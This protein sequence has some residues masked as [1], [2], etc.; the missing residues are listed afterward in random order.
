MKKSLKKVISLIL[1]AVMTFGVCAVSASAYNYPESSKTATVPTVYVQGYGTAIYADKNDPNSGIIIGGGQDFI[2]DGVLGQLISDIMEP[3]FKGIATGDY[4]E[5][6]DTIVNALVADLGRFALDENGEASD[7][8]GN[9]CNWDKATNNRNWYGGK[10]HIQEYL[11]GYDWRVDIFES[12]GNLNGYI[13]QVKKVT[14][15]DKVNLVGRCMGANIVLAYLSEYGYDSINSLSL[16]IAGLDGFETVTSFF[17][18]EIDVDTDALI[19]WLYQQEVSEDYD[20]LV[21]FLKAFAT[22]I[23]AIDGLNLPLELVYKIYDQVYTDIIPRVLRE[24]F[25]SMPA[26][27]SCVAPGSYETA[28]AL[29]FPTEVE[30]TKY[31][32]LIEK[33]DRYY[34]QV[35][36]HVEDIINTA[37]DKGIPVYMFAKYGLASAPINDNAKY[38]SDGTVSVYTQALGATSTEM[39][40]TF[41]KTYLEN[42]KEDG[43]YKYISPDKC[44]DAS[45]GI[46]PDSTWYIKGSNHGT[47][48][49]AIDVMMAA[50]IDATGYGDNKTYVTVDTLEEYPQ[51]NLM[52]STDRDAYMQPLTEE[53]ANYGDEKWNV[54]VFEQLSYFFEKLFAFITEFVNHIL[55]LIESTEI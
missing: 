12:A 16:Y 14:G 23:N 9:Q 44:L 29:C 34:N 38:H 41:S 21:S 4:T 10:Y 52:E 3:L 36:L 13:E 35:S 28:I 43:T 42:A 39:G 54:N 55:Y 51:Y 25:G 22:I 2:S 37:V 48:P 5:Y 50:I 1:C 40:K 15:Y 24:S 26:F 6:N 8:S 7:G 45:T 17:S 32:K 19:R 53:N 20:E 46:L 27:W 18:G 30:Q 33:T 11:F 47:M 49:R 31:A